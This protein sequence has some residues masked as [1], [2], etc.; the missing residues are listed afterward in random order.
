VLNIT[1]TGAAYVIS[2][3]TFEVG[4]YLLGQRVKEQVLG[5]VFHFC[6]ANYANA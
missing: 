4:A 2:V 1:V 5:L 3:P 6:V